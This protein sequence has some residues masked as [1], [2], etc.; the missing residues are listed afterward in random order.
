MLACHIPFIFFTGK[1]SLL[2]IIDEMRRNSISE[3]LQ[4]QIEQRTYERSN[5]TQ[6]IFVAG[7]MEFLP[8]GSINEEDIK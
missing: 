2:I 3:A 7:G 6:D 5:S 8:A 1:E 4:K